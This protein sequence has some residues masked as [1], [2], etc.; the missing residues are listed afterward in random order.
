MTLVRCAIAQ[1]VWTNISLER[2]LLVIFDSISSQCSAQVTTG[3]S[4]PPRGQREA[5]NLIRNRCQFYVKIG[6]KRRIQ[7]I[8]SFLA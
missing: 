1:P 5:S 2:L 3:A 7:G 6:K 4:F 8:Q